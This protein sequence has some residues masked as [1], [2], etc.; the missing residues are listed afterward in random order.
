MKAL[1]I[2]LVCILTHQTYAQSNSTPIKKA[3]V[4]LLNTSLPD[5]ELYKK[6]GAY[7]LS[8]GY[9]LD[10]SDA[11]LRSITTAKRKCPGANCQYVIYASTNEG[12]IRLSGGFIVPGIDSDLWPIENR[13]QKTSPFMVSFNALNKVALDLQSDTSGQLHYAVQ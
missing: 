4:I 6:V 12:K 10:R 5:E 3:N 1:V 8:A 9:S 2:A 13:G 7:L 11:T